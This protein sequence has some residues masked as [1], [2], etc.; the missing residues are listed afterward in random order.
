M[1]D[2]HTFDFEG[3]MLEGV[4]GFFRSFGGVQTPYFRLSKGYIGLWGRLR[5]K[6]RA[7]YASGQQKQV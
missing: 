5:R 6:W 4:E 1:E 2:I 3:S 7:T